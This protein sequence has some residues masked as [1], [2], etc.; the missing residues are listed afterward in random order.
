M[1]RKKSNPKYTLKW[2]SLLSGDF[3]TGSPWFEFTI[4]KK[5]GGPRAAVAPSRKTVCPGSR[6]R[7]RFSSAS[8]CAAAMASG[9]RRCRGLEWHGDQCDNIGHEITCTNSNIM[10]SRPL[11]TKF[12]NEAEN[13]VCWAC[14]EGGDNVKYQNAYEIRRFLISNVLVRQVGKGDHLAK[15]KKGCQPVSLFP[16]QK[17]QVSQNSVRSNGVHVARGPL[18]KWVPTSHGTWVPARTTWSTWS[19]K[20]VNF[21]APIIFAN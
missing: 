20:P 3:K 13:W 21:A 8:R 2:N 15:A 19:S 7:G 11:K 9:L 10:F 5:P 18:G 16:V 12:W 1:E 14:R 17:P 4:Y 6:S